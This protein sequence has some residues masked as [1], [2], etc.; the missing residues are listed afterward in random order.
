LRD[1]LIVV[2]SAN[3][4]A[5]ENVTKELPSAKK[6]DPRYVDR[7]GFFVPTADALLERP[8]DE[9]E[10]EEEDEDGDHEDAGP[11]SRMCAPGD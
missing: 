5:V 1:H 7:L 10:P 9:D 6:V 3:N 11:R 8:P 2:A 4:A